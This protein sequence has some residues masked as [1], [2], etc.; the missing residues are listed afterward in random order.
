MKYSHIA[1]SSLNFIIDDSVIKEN[2]LV[3]ISSNDMIV[4]FGI[5]LG[6]SVENQLIIIKNFRSLI[7][8]YCN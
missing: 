8:N 6:Y 1:I 2:T 3:E 7:H 5:L 4:L